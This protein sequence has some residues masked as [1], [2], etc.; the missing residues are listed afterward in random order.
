MC[1]YLH[2]TVA[3]LLGWL[4]PIQNLVLHL[5][6]LPE[7]DLQM[8]CIK[9]KSGIGIPNIKGN[10]SY[11]QRTVLLGFVAFLQGLLPLT[12]KRFSS[13]DLNFLKCTVSMNLLFAKAPVNLITSSSGNRIHIQK[14]ECSLF[15]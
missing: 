10:I 1:N 11:S 9:S 15:Q 3:I 6:I 12:T 4:Q 2:L 13:T 8:P 14:V 7:L 5:E